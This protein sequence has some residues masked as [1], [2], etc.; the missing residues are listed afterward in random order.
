MPDI[1]I[2]PILGQ[3]VI[4]DGLRRAG[5]DQTVIWPSLIGVQRSV[6]WFPAYCFNWQTA[7]AV[8]VPPLH[9]IDHPLAVARLVATRP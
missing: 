4:R 8:A 3:W 7:K 6:Q 2:S 9:V 1:G 5:A